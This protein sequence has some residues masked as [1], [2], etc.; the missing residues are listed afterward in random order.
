MT[1]ASEPTTNT[2]LT[3]NTTDSLG[4]NIV[5]RAHTSLVEEQEKEVG[6]V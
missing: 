5:E 3:Q 1:T 2:T 6:G 4:V